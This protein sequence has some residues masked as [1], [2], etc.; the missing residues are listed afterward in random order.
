MALIIVEETETNY[1]NQQF[2]WMMFILV[3]FLCCMAVILPVIWFV[4]AFAT[5]IA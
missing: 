5:E 2:W 1:V 3:D 4:D